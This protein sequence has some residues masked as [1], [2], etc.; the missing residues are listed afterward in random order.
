MSRLKWAEVRGG[1]LNVITCKEGGL[2][3]CGPGLRNQE[4]QQ[5]ASLIRMPRAGP[6]AGGGQVRAG[7]G[8][9]LP[10]LA[11]VSL[12]YFLSEGLRWP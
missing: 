6:Q 12:E 8:A 2:A 4:G 10:T 7:P 1:A 5:R 3:F 9:P 11:A